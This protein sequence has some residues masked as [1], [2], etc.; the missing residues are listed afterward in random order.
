[1]LDFNHRP[2]LDEQISDVDRSGTGAGTREPDAARLSRRIPPRRGLRARAAV[3]VR[4]DPVTSVAS[5]P[6]ACCASS[7]SATPWRTWPSAGCAWP[8]SISTPEGTGWSVRLLGRRRAHP[9]PRRRHREWR[10]CGSGDFGM[11]FPA[12]GVQDHER[13][14]LA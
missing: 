6:A 10:S 12:L 2:K 8:A 7:R 3:R 13:Q 4:H 14:E 5:F 9:G 11:T 1:M